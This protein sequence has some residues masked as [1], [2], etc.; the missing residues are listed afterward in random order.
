[1]SNTYPKHPDNVPG[2]GG[3]LE[4]LAGA[5]ENMRYDRAYDFVYHLTRAF[6]KRAL[7][8]RVT[9]KKKLADRLTDTANHLDEASCELFNAWIVCKPHMGVEDED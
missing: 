9:G 3:T 5:V 1:M 6:R 2:W 7:R 4:E 8:D